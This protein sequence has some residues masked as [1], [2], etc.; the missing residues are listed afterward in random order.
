MSSKIYQAREG[1]R[2][3]ESSRR[4]GLPRRAKVHVEPNSLWNLAP[5]IPIATTSTG[6]ANDKT[7]YCGRAAPAVATLMLAFATGV[8]GHLLTDGMNALRGRNC[9]PAYTP[10]VTQPQE[11][12]NARHIQHR[13]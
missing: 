12:L 11:N 2:G 9:P 8:L 6:T 5:G 1:P 10:N 13:C 3:R 4:R 7:K